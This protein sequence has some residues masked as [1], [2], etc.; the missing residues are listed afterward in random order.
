MMKERKRKGVKQINNRT[1]KGG[2]R[3]EARRRGAPNK[4]LSVRKLSSEDVEWSPMRL[5]TKREERLSILINK[6][7][8][9]QSSLIARTCTKTH[10][11][12]YEQQFFTFMV[13]GAISDEDNSGGGASPSKNK[14][15]GC[16]WCNFQPKTTQ[17]AVGD[18]SPS[19]SAFGGVSPA[20]GWSEMVG[21]VVCNSSRRF[22]VSLENLVEE[23]A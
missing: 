20:V 5:E 23:T 18:V 7:K 1:H 4:E 17:C 8:R 15:S 9:A 19:T 10:I 11:N 21:N 2:T 14:H 22:C 12:G 3:R 6:A 16:R 13:G